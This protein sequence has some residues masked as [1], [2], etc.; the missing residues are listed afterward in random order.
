MGFPAVSGGGG[1]SYYS[2]IL[3]PEIDACAKFKVNG[4]L[5]REQKCIAKGMN[6]LS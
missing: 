5:V 3:S 4:I 2:I 6:A 1:G